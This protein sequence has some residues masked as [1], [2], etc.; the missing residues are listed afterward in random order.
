MIEKRTVPR[1]RVLKRGSLA[2]NGG[3]AMDCIVRNLSQTGARIEI[4]SPVGVPEVF[5]LVI[6]S[7]HFKRR[8]HA[9]WSSERRIG[10]AFD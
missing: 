4:A 7:D 5:T 1:H 9:I 2:F 3:G 6:E 8:C 10:V